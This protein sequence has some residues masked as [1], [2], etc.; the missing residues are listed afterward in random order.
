[1]LLDLLM[2]HMDGWGLLDRLQADVTVQTDPQVVL[3]PAG[4]ALAQEGPPW[5]SPQVVA[6]LPKPFDSTD[7]LAQVHALTS[8]SPGEQR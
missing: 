6:D 7:L 1:M 2:P 5:R 3:M 4:W 8:A